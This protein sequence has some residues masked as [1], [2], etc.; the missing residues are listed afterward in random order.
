MTWREVQTWLRVHQHLLRDQ[1]RWASWMIATAAGPLL[2]VA[3][4]SED[5]ASIVL[6]TRVA[7]E[8]VEEELILARLRPEI[9][10]RAIAE[11]PH[12]ATRVRW[13]QGRATPAASLGSWATQRMVRTR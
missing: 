9:L 1:P 13:R 8:D 3:R 2:V 5:G 11:L 7:G 12:V 4:I 10:H 6:A